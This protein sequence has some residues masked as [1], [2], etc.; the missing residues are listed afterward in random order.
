MSA[1]KSLLAVCSIIK[2]QTKIS[3]S[4]NLYRFSVFFMPLF[5]A[6]LLYFIYPP[7]K[8]ESLSAYIIF[9][10]GIAS[11]WGVTCYSSSIEIERERLSGTLEAV[12]ITPVG[13]EFII[14][15]KIIANTIVGSL[16]FVIVTLYALA[17]LRLHVGI[18]NIALFATSFITLLIAFI[19][20]SFVVATLFTLSRNA[21]ALMS[22]IQYPIY[23][24][25]GMLF[26][27]EILPR[28]VQVIAAVLPVRW[29]VKI[30]NFSLT[31]YNFN[32]QY[33]RMVLCCFVLS[34]VYF[35]LGHVLFKIIE[36]KSRY[37]ATLG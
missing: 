24:I 35:I 37:E 32:F 30:L 10:S 14:I 13:L 2:T 19:S 28:W 23:L 22:T 33:F 5:F 25:S 34:I 29:G 20:T 9:G 17:V 11:L 4:R 31:I 27:V 16:S 6:T 7:S 21:F 1:L 36:Y 15:C 18:Q 26:P 12:S 3:M 8:H